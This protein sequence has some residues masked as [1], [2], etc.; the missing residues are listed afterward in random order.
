MN[1]R[2]PADAAAEKEVKTSRESALE[3]WLAGLRRN[4]KCIIQEQWKLLL[5]F[6]S[7]LSIQYILFQCFAESDLRIS[8]SN[9]RLIA[10]TLKRYVWSNYYCDI[11]PIT[12]STAA[13]ERGTNNERIMSENPCT[14]IYA[15]LFLNHTY[16]EICLF[17]NS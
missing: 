13:L 10:H 6:C 2:R 12:C 16:S 9:T 17:H 8:R 4:K 11:I 5:N 7:T 3:I 15:S 14:Q 1:P